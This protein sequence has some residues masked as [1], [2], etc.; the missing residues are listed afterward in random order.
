VQ[1]WD[2]DSS[3]I[4]NASLDQ[5]TMTSAGEYG[6]QVRSGARGGATLQN[7]TVSSPGMGG[8]I[9]QSAA[10]QFTLQRGAGNSGW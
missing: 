7:V 10:G 3:S 1:S 8:L 9:D 2:S 4:R 5:I 6:I